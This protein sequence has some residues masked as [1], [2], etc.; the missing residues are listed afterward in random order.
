M[1]G[2]V[3]L[4]RGALV[5]K[6]KAYF[7]LG[8]VYCAL[9]TMRVNLSS[10]W[11][12][13]PFQSCFFHIFKINLVWPC[14]VFLYKQFLTVIPNWNYNWW[15][16]IRRKTNMFI[17]QNLA[18]TKYTYLNRYFNSVVTILCRKKVPIFYKSIVI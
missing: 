2:Y 12:W 13:K 9:W 4:T 5:M 7:S 1:T 10:I 18:F 14:W 15:I 11:G 8:E 3:Q 16:Y 6:R 17:T